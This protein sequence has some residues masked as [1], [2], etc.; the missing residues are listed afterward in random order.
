MTILTKNKNIDELCKII[1]KLDNKEDI[2]T[3]LKE[4]LTESELQDIAQRWNIL[5][6]LSEN[7]TQRN[8]ANTLSASLCN[9]TRGSKI[10]KKE[11]S[12]IRKILFDESWRNSF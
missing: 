9:V 4:L 12:L 11:K 5:K 3:F 6:L 7:Q 2:E 8:I 10:L 1:A